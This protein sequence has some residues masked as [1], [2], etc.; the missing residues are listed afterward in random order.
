MILFSIDK[1]IQ[2][3]DS[4]RKGSVELSISSA[5]IVKGW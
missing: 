2:T 5:K 3:S 1:H 4:L